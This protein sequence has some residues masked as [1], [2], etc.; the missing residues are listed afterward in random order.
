MSRRDA[1]DALVVGAGVV[2]AAAS[3]ALARAGLRVGIVEAHEPP[4]WRADSP[5][6]RVYALAPDARAL[7]DSL[8][9][10]ASVAAARVHPYRR[11]RVWDAAGGA[12]LDFDADA[13]GQECLGHIVE[14]GLLVDR[15]WAAIGREPGIE[16][17]CP[18]KLETLEQD[19]DGVEVGLAGGRRLRAALL[20]GA[21]GASSRVRSLAGIDWRGGG[22][23]Q[24]AIV[25][26]V[27]CE[28]AHE[29]TCWQRFLPSGP[30]AF[31]PCAEGRCSIV[32]TLP[33]AEA[34]RLLAVDEDRFRAELE[35]AF[36]ARLGAITSV[37]A[38]RAFPLERR[39]ADG[40]L[41]GRV[42]LL[43]D[44]AH[45]VHPLAGQGVNLGLRDVAALAE[46][47]RAARAAGRDPAGPRLARW[48]R[49]RDSEN[50]LAAHA[51]EAINRVFSDRCWDWRSCRRWRAC[52]GGAPP[53]PEPRRAQPGGARNSRGDSEPSWF[54]SWRRNC[55]A[56][57]AR[58][59]ASVMRGAR[60]TSCSFSSTT[61]SWLRSICR[62]A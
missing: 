26:Y 53:A 33:E 21:D 51:L 19:E 50:A 14:H 9:A 12:E 52:F 15:L 5:D 41:H 8:G 29:D 40:M 3:L 35:R 27:A 60:G 59:C 36:D 4:A 39:L 54:L 25:A 10:W 45:V 17:H 43:G 62:K 20:F 37:S 46:T 44:A 31:L 49:A 57:C 22:Y 24:R 58:S 11:M 13:L 56:S 34:E 47:V 48:A 16:R 18:E 32:W 42:A 23:G 2:G 30:L 28:R 38:R 61:S 1:L 55:S 6:L 7:L